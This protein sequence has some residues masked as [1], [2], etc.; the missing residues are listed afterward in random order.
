MAL[1]FIS[2]YM[3][4]ASQMTDAQL[5][6]MR[7]RLV[8]WQ[9]AF[10]PDLDTRPQSVFGTWALEPMAG[11]LA[12]VEV[13]M[14]RMQQDLDV[15]GVAA[16]T[17]FNCD[18]VERYLVAMGAQRQESVEVWGY[19]RLEFDQ[20]LDV[21]IPGGWQMVFNDSD[22]FEI[23]TPDSAEVHLLRRG[24]VRTTPGSFVL[25]TL[26]GSRVA[27]IVP[28]RGYA[29]RAIVA[30][31]EAQV[32]V[33]ID[34]LVSATAV[35][36]FSIGKAVN[37]VPALA[38]RTSTRCHASG[39]ITR[40]GASNEITT[41]WPDVVGVSAVLPGDTEM[42]RGSNN[43]L[44][45]VRNTVDLYIQSTQGRTIFTQTV[46][47]PYV[48]TQEAAT[49]DAFIAAFSP[50]AVPRRLLSITPVTVPGMVLSSATAYLAQR[51]SDDVKAPR[52]A[53]SFSP[54]ATFELIVHMPRAT[55]GAPLIDLET[56][57]D[58][59]YALFDVTYEADP[60]VEAVNAYV[61][62]D[63]SAGVDLLVRSPV[64]IIIE[65]M[66][67]SY[68]RQPGVQ[69]NT[70]QVRTELAAYILS[71]VPPAGFDPARLYDM[72][73][74]AGA[75][76][77]RNVDLV[78]TMPLSVA[79]YVLDA[80]DSLAATDYAGWLADRQLVEVVTILDI[81]GLNTTYVDP[82]PGLP[83]GKFLNVSARN[84]G[85]VLIQEGL[86]FHHST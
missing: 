46:R 48:A 19:V 73:Y 67:V 6:S 34:G 16:G 39:F 22:V 30:G 36:A 32:A 41:A 21:D 2:T 77:V 28:V 70:E 74:Y 20:D 50:A 63:V 79:R 84:A 12:A 15:R 31:S 38:A 44:G 60:A 13:G 17:V 24:S 56:D 8:T 3:P 4:D 45:L 23:W 59:S 29:E 69:L 53:C 47:V 71:L 25:H 1:D 43:P 82:Y 27:V 55:S 58:G 10:S 35:S 65:Q 86:T 33:A 7:E 78:A 61:Q 68:V 11:L 76:R 83:S 26:A 75:A 62:A 18:F 81:T 80:D 66:A 85:M 42:A 40:A 51:S 64:P 52:L 14:E 72:M 54:L 57:E 9:A 49:V 5:S 37:S